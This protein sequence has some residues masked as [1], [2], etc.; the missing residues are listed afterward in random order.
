MSFQGWGETFVW[1]ERAWQVRGEEAADVA[2]PALL[3]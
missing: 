1:I 2:F 3:F